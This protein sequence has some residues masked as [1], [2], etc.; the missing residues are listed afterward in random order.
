MKEDEW[1]GGKV[2]EREMGWLKIIEKKERKND[3]GNEIKMK[4]IEKEGNRSLDGVNE[5]EELRI[6]WNE[7]II[8]E[9]VKID[10]IGL[11]NE[12]NLGNGIEDILRV[13]KIEIDMVLR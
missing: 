6:G 3:R 13:G 1:D 10:E 2:E 9:G 12:E 4:K 11:K 7:R 8:E 5:E